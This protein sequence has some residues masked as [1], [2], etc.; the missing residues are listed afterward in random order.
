[1]TDGSRVVATLDVVV[2]WLSVVV[3]LV[4]V[5]TEEEDHMVLGPSVEVIK[6]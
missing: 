3:T 1:M 2:T 6:L 4:V 5:T